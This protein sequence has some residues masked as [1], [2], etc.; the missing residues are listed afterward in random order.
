M[1]IR[2]QLPTATNTSPS[3]ASPTSSPP[4]GETSRNPSSS[5]LSTGA[6]A[7]IGAG[8]GLA[9]LI[10]LVV[11]GLFLFR[12]RKRQQTPAYRAAN[13]DEQ[14]YAERYAYKQDPDAYIGGSSELPAGG[15]TTSVKHEMPAAVEA[16]SELPATEVPVEVAATHARTGE[17]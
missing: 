8:V 3:N 5:G 6:K 12:R 15:D 10:A 14:V 4:A 13:A 1:L 11:L 16:P 9:A 17:R 2:A 7:G